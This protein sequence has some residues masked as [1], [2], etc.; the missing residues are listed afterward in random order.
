MKVV[1][2]DARVAG[3]RDARS[4]V[5]FSLCGAIPSYN[6]HVYTVG[7]QMYSRSLVVAPML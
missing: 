7:T 2:C 3:A 6:T 4:L 1:C 5:Y